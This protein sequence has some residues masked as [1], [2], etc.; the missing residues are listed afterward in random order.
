MNMAFVEDAFKAGLSS[1]ARDI[2]KVERQIK[3]EPNNPVLH[4]MLGRMRASKRQYAAA[5]RSWREAIRLS[6]ATN[7][8]G[9]ASLRELIAETYLTL[10][11]SAAARREY[12]HAARW[13]RRARSKALAAVIKDD[14]R[15]REAYCLAQAGRAG[16]AV[17]LLR[18][19][20]RGPNLETFDTTIREISQRFPA[21]TLGDRTNNA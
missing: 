10:G 14:S 12:A 17:R 5:C 4:A 2:A 21:L 11:R 3:R 8:L 7:P 19:V 9:V 16:E 6:R 20:R 1:S 15:V 18:Q 13:F